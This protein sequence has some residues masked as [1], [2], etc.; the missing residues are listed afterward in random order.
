[1]AIYKESMRYGALALMVVA[2]CK[3]KAVNHQRPTKS[4]DAAIAEHVADAAPI[5]APAKAA[6]PEHTAWS[7]VDN[8]HLAHRGVAGELVLDATTAGF[9]R[10]THF[11]TPID[12]WHLGAQ[13]DN[14]RAALADRVA[15]LDVPIIPE[16]TP[17]TQITA[18]VNAAEK[19]QVL[20]VKVNGVL[21]SK[22]AKIPLEI[23]WQTIAIEVDAG[24]L[25]PGENDVAFETVGGKGKKGVAFSWLRFGATHPSADE[26]PLKATVFDAKA[27]A[28][29]LAEGASLTWYVTI[30]DGA[31]LVGEVAATCHVEV[32]ARAGDGNLVGGMLGA[33]QDRVD[34]SAMSGKVVRLSLTA[35]DC[36]RARITHP[37]VTLHGPEP[38]RM[39]KAEPPKLVILWMMDALR[40]DK[41]PIFTP[42]ARAQTPNFDELA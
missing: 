42:G 7:L 17:P 36:P 24:K 32:G 23:G 28:I 34:L 29:E 18:R 19:K 3:G 5:D 40:A 22:L 31:H 13:I 11:G 39:P 10:Y 30:P 6:R 16:Q 9:A 33:D 12:R 27:D 26:E 35:R 20:A 4:G 15:A 25:K 1:M 41:I 2:A 38:T 8:R 21:A 37:R 14:E